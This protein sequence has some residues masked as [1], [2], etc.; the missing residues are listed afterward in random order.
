MTFLGGL[1][2]GRFAMIVAGRAAP[3]AAGD[4]CGFGVCS[5]GEDADAGRGMTI[6]K[7][8]VWYEVC[9]LGVGEGGNEKETGGIC[10]IFEV[11]LRSCR[12]FLDQRKFV[13][14]VFVV[15]LCMISDTATASYTMKEF[16]NFY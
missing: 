8:I 12:C 2:L 1:P 13:G 16:I 10:T 7:R 15:R 4:G 6:S 3:A 14:I 9:G 5:R 11:C